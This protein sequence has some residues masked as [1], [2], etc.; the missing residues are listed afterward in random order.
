[1]DVNGCYPRY[2]DEALEKMPR[3]KLRELQ[4]AL[5]KNTVDAVYSG[6]PYYRRS[7]GEARVKP[8][9]IR[10]LEDI[11]KL[12]FTDK[13][14]LRARQEALPPFGDLICVPEKKIVYIAVSSGSTGVPTVSPFTAG[15]FEAW[16]D[17]EARMFWSSGMRPD[18]RYCHALDLALYVSGPNVLGAQ[19]V[20][21][22]CIWA[23]TMDAERMLAII[24]RWS[25]TVTWLTP[26]Y[27]WYLAE[28][29]RRINID[30]ACD[31]SLRKIFVAGEPGGSVAATKHRLEELWGAS[32]Y[33]YYGFS[34]LFGAFSCECE[35]KNGLHLAEDQVFVEILDP[36]AGD[37][38]PEGKEGELVVTSL[39][40]RAR[41]LI[42]FKTGD[43]VASWTREPCS[44]GRSHTRLFGI[45]GRLDD[46]IVID[47]VGIFPSAV[48]NIVRRNNNLSGEFKIVVLKERHIDQISIEV[49]HSRGFSGNLDD[50]NNQLQMDCYKH[51]G[52][53]PLVRII[54]FGKLF[55]A[56]R[57][58][59]RVID[60]RKE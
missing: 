52:I 46:R 30:P 23:G 54:P 47:G 39:K 32:I 6:S 13:E 57:K 55:R 9:D 43:M 58:T 28:A 26:S 37:D 4:F 60:L 2:W 22:L 19:K 35:E 40:K 1:M 3:E 14:I 20:G 44:C 24:Q 59:N 31:L 10:C 27:A 38:V 17:C 25:P 8:E 5:L 36:V 48:E 18:D 16:Q 7:F 56:T 41:P 34:D 29:A 51:L 49:E 15:D 11:K 50:L 33:D 42:R 53:E 12:P 45:K 21:A